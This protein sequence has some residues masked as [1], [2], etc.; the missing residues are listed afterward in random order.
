MSKKIV[1]V[2]ALLPKP[3][4]RDKGDKPNVNTQWKI[5]LLKEV[6]R[7]ELLGIELTP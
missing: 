4:D 7:L 1:Y 6:A 5:I 2:T 3:W